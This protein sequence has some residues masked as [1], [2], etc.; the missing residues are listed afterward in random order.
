MTQTNITTNANELREELAPVY[1]LYPGQTQPQSA[2]LEL[3]P[4]ARTLRGDYSG[5]IGG[6][7]PMAVWHGRI[8]RFSI[9][10]FVTG[11][12]LAGLLEQPELLALAAR[13]CDG[14]EERWSGSDL[15]GYFAT[16]DAA[17][18]RWELERYLDRWMAGLDPAESLQIM[19]PEEWLDDPTIIGLT[20]ETTDAELL[21]LTQREIE[22][23]ASERILIDGDLLAW[24]G[25]L[26]DR[27]REQA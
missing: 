7:V 16:D 4:R 19:Q 1:R 24:L 9:T 2:Y 15:R 17:A 22:H 18:A 12:Q 3:D 10:P 27:L 26:R 20:G 11:R 21:A 13:L 14:Y 23:A 6:A 5:E 8:R 25:E